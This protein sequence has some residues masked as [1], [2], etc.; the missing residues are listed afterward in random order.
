MLKLFPSISG[1]CIKQN[2]W[3]N[4]DGYAIFSDWVEEAAKNS[5][6]PGAMASKG[7]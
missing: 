2:D 7:K 1:I 3:V 4:D 5:G 6:R